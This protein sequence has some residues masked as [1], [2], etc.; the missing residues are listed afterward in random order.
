MTRLDTIL[1]A[2]VDALS[3]A[4]FLAIA[5]AVGALAAASFGA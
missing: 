5:I 2:V 3:L 4:A 1:G